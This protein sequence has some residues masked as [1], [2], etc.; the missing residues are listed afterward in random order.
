MALAVINHDTDVFDGV[1]CHKTLRKY[2]TH[3]FFNG[4]DEVVGNDAAL[5]LINKLKP[6][7]ARQ[8]FNAQIHFTELT[9]T[10]RLFF[11]TGVTF[12]RCTDRFPV[13][14]RRNRGFDFE[15]KVRAHTVQDGANMHVS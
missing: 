3:A 1:A 2:L 9:C 5:D 15:L 4:R 14:N 13:R 8:R 11:M 7:A 10:A 12:G 6:L